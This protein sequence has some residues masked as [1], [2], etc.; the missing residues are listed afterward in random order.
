[1]AYHS[2]RHLLRI[3]LLTQMRA[4]CPDTRRSISGYAIYLGDNLVSWRSKK[5]PTVSRSSCESEY[6][7]LASTAAEVKWLCH[8][9]RDLKVNV[10]ST[11]LLLCDN[12]S[13]IFLAANPVSH[14][15]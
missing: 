3:F 7:A 6:R 15:R 9:L 11:P 5:Q 1:M 8:L 2:L 14:N 10:P 4:G 12:Q 13:A